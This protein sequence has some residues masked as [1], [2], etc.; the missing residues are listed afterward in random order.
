[1]KSNEK[2]AKSENRVLVIK[3]NSKLKTL[4]LNKNGKVRQSRKTKR[5]EKADLVEKILTHV[6]DICEYVKDNLCTE[7]C[8]LEELEEMLWKLAR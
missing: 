4:K 5:D 2:N 6:S 8:Q 1:M 7:E 3:K